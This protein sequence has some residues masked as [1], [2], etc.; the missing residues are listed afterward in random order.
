MQ[1]AQ[2]AH[3]AQ[4]ELKV[5]PDRQALQEHRVQQVLK[6]QQVQ[7]AQLG[8]LGRKVQQVRLDVPRPIM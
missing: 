7:Q 4:R 8:L 3:R 6:D 2:Q 1:L 5:L